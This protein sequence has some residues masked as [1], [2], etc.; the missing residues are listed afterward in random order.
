MPAPFFV[1]HE[2]SSLAGAIARRDAGATSAAIR[3]DPCC[4]A[5]GRGSVFSGVIRLEA[6]P[7][8]PM[9]VNGGAQADAGV[10]SLH[11]LTKRFQQLLCAFL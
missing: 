9:V 3:P 6:R 11:W 1:G 7:S 4:Y 10:D 2:P 5:R 8:G